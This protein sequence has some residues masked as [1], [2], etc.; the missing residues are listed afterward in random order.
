MSNDSQAA[1]KRVYGPRLL[2]LF[3]VWQ[4]ISGFVL[5]ADWRRE[6]PGYSTWIRS[7]L[8]DQIGAEYDT[9][10]RAIR[11]GRGF[12]DPFREPTGPTAWMPPVLVY[13]TAGLY[14]L[15]EDDRSTVIAI[16]V[17]LNA[18]VMGLTGYIVVSEA[19]RLRMIWLGCVILVLGMCA[20]FFELYQRTHDTWLVLLLLNLTWI[21]LTWYGHIWRSTAS[22]VAWGVLGGVCALSSPIAGWTWAMATTVSWLQGT[23]STW[24]REPLTTIGRNR[25]LW[26]AALVSVVVVTPWTIRNRVVLGKWMP[27]KSNGVYELWQSQVLDD[28]GVLD[29]TSAFQHPW[30]S[31]NEQ[32]AEYVEQGEIEFVQKRW[33]PTWESMCDSP[34]GVLQRI[35]N[36]WFAAC[37]YYQPLIPEDERLVWPM[38]YKRLVFPLPMLFALIILLWRPRP[39]DLAIRNTFVIGGCYLLPYVLVSYYDRYAAPLIT[40]KSLVLLYGMHTLRLRFAEWQAKKRPAGMVGDVSTST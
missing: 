13:V 3:L 17:I 35:S 22:L 20:D 7:D 19:R 8:S 26:T 28:D 33:Q 18:I 29:R 31:P 40:A 10:A 37:V 32:R 21:G 25:R 24:L 16:I 1:A 11:V 14:W 2:D 4:I 39:L 27:I 36:R 23:P 12:S 34:I 9:I 30:G 6:H 15:T 38:R 5:T